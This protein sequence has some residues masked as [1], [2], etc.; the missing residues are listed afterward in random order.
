MIETPTG[1]WTGSGRRVARVGALRLI[2]AAACLGLLAPAAMAS[3]TWTNYT[4]TTNG[5]GSNRVR[6]VYA[7]G[8]T[9]YAATSVGVSVSTN[10]GTNWTNSTTTNGLGNN[11]LQGVYASGGTIYAATWGGGLS[12]STN[13][14]TNW[15]N[16]TTADGL[17]SNGVQGVYAIGSTIYAATFGGGL[18]IGVTAAAV[19]GTGL[20]GLA[21]LGFAGS[22]RRR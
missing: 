20:A 18:S 22:R 1:I 2:A 10:N 17:G 12:V 4:T 19:P 7:S 9:I 5:L 13:G 3:V 14:G 8:S 11:N 21:M 16:Y 15:T 6:G